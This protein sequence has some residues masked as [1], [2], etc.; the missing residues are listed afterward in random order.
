MS[1]ENSK[2]KLTLAYDGTSFHGWQVQKDHATIQGTLQE[3]LFKATGK[4]LPLTGCS[5]TDAGVH[6]LEYVCHTDFISIPCDKIPLALNAHLPPEI[7]VKSAQLAESDFHARYNCRGKEYIYK[8]LNTHLRDPFLANRAMFY[9]KHLD[10][11]IMNEA[12]QGICG[13]KDFRAFMAQGSPVPDTVRTV[14]YCDVFRQGDI[15]TVRVAADGFLYNMVR[16]IVGTLMGASE[17][18]L[19]KNDIE[20]IIDSLDRTK[21]GAT[22]PACGLYLNKVFY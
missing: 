4:E 9:P 2:I 21:A 19:T 1:I 15:V 20:N 16:I 22:V 8:I 17:K 5:R 18:K 3:A 7:I 13:K 14:Q 12:A 10:E 11:N 6:A